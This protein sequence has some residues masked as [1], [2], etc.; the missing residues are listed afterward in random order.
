MVEYI[1]HVDPSQSPACDSELIGQFPGPSD[2]LLVLDQRQGEIHIPDP[3]KHNPQSTD[4]KVQVVDNGKPI[5][6]M[7]ME[8]ASVYIN[9]RGY[10]G[11][12]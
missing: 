7:D 10:A 3:V 5:H 2:P 11:G 9:S 6:C 4:T 12:V 1:L 8:S